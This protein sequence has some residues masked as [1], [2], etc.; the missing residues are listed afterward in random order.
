M[1]LAFS[2]SRRLPL[3]SE[4]SSQVVPEVS[5]FAMPRRELVFE[6]RGGGR[7]KAT[8]SDRQTMETCGRRE[9]RRQTG[10]SYRLIS[11][12]NTRKTTTATL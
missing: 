11:L 2:G 1:R 5:F 10:R 3:D 7:R 12:R 4:D 6:A 9:I 8:G